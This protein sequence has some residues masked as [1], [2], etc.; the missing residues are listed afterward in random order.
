MN[1]RDFFG[2]VWDFFFC[3]TLKKFCL[4][5][6][7]FIGS[8]LDYSLSLNNSVLAGLPG[9]TGYLKQEG[10]CRRRRKRRKCSL[11]HLESNNRGSLQSCRH[12]GY[13]HLKELV[14]LHKCVFRCC[15][16]EWRQMRRA[17]VDGQVLLLP[18]PQHQQLLRLIKHISF[19]SRCVLFLCFI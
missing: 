15:F 8:Y 14:K 12:T 10:G 16:Q 13:F 18:V 2:R 6:V 5:N 17:L 4:C 19:L 7:I 11:S 9:P 1:F 3:N